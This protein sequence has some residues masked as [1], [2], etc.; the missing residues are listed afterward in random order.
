ML[1]ISIAGFLFFATIGTYVSL[2]ESTQASTN[3][4]GNFGD[5]TDDDTEDN[6]DDDTND[7]N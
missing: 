1:V 4:E 6:T 7:Q 2:L 3:N 5:G